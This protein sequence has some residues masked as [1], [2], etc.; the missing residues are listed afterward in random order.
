MLV[1]HNF[2]PEPVEDLNPTDD[3][4]PGEEAEHA[5]NPADLVR[6]WHFS[7]TSDL[8]V[9]WS[10]S[11]QLYLCSIPTLVITLSSGM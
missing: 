8:K 4:E 11:P 3:R 10:V 9:D 1:K 6:E 2:E 5:T 7:V